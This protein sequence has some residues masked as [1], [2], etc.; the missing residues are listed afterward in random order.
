MP[1]VLIA[2]GG[3]FTTG[4]SPGCDAA[5]LPIFASRS[6]AS[7]TKLF[8]DNND[9]DQKQIAPNWFRVRAEVPLI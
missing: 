8:R 6:R 4:I 5:S 3:S 2:A 9:T 7:V 1:D